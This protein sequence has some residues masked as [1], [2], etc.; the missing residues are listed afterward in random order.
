MARSGLSAALALAY[1]AK[2]AEL[3][4]IESVGINDA[5]SAGPHIGRA[6]NSIGRPGHLPGH[7][8][9]MGSTR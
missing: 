1:R 5:G 7:L 6:V 8:K 2:S 9:E 3:G 4:L